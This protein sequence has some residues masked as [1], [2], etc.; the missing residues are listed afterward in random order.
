MSRFIAVAN[1]GWAEMQFCTYLGLGVVL[2]IP[3]FGDLRSSVSPFKSQYS[4]P[5]WQPHRTGDLQ[6]PTE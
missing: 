2:E 5:S 6:A 3:S 4:Y 1:F